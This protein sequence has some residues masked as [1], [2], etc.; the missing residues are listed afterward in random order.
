MPKF[1]HSN[2][3]FWVIF[4]HCDSETHHILH[5]LLSTLGS[6]PAELHLQSSKVFFLTDPDIL[7]SIAW[8]QALD[9]TFK[10]NMRR[11]PGIYWQSFGSQEGILRM[12]PASQWQTVDDL[13]DLFDVRRRPWYIQGTSSPK[14]MVILLDTW[15]LLLYRCPNTF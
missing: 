3:T 15:V 13:P 5:H 9:E 14:D 8:T 12:Y 6:Y 11:Y 2:G 7:N 4:K 1:K 10:A